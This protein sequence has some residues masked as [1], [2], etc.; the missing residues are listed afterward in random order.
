M[1]FGQYILKVEVLV[2]EALRYNMEPSTCPSGLTTIEIL[3]LELH[4]SD[5]MHNLEQ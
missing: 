1:A 5:K 3:Q 2:T 4:C